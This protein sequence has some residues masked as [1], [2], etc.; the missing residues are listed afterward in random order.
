VS[1]VRCTLGTQ[2]RE[3]GDQV[4]CILP[5]GY[6]LWICF[7]DTPFEYA[8][9]GSFF[10]PS[11]Q[12][13][14]EL[15]R[16]YLPI[17]SVR[18][19]PVNHVRDI[20]PQS[21]HI[22]HHQ[23]VPCFLQAQQA[24]SLV[25]LRTPYG[26]RRP[27]KNFNE[28]CTSLKHWKVRFFLINRR[29][30]PDAMPWRHKNS[31][32]VDPLPTS[33]RAEDIHRLCESIIDVRPVHPAMLYEISL[34]TIWKHVGYHTVL[35]DGEGNASL[36][37]SSFPCLGVH[38]GKGTAL[39]ANKVVAQ[40]T[41]TP[42]PPGSQ[43]TEKSDYQK[44]FEQSEPNNSTCSVSGTRHSASPLTT[45]IPN[46][47]NP[48]PGGWN[49]TLESPNRPKGDTE[50]SLDNAKNDTE[51]THAHFD[52]DGLYH[53][54]RYEHIYRNI[55]FRL[56]AE[57][58][59]Q[60]FRPSGSSLQANVSPPASFVPVWNLTTYSILNDDESCRD[61]MINLGSSISL[62]VHVKMF[63]I[64]HLGCVGKE[65]TLIEKLVAVEKEKDKLLDKNREQE[66]QIRRLEETLAS[67]TS[68]LSEAESADR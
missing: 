61:M 45:I 4:V 44:V 48:T 20:L 67:K 65:E 16:T 6:S 27:R 54:K 10:Y 63:S 1:G 29:V 66:E 19:E 33:V 22:S 15:S 30:I 25:L 2:S 31:S 57:F 7:L 12:C 62:I 41:T 60:Q 50:N 42:L 23:P 14:Y 53:D 56:R 55:L 39:V 58:F 49:L 18:L 9:R 38:I 5:F 47:T 68:S 32:M 59:L 17:S 3:I 8:F 36:N 43:I 28:F 40:H 11:P 52:G 64:G 35:K 46:D 21:K 24:G 34:T 37:F 51:D 13:Y 26:K